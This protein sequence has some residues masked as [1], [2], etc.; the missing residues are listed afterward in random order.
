[1]HGAIWIGI[2]F[3]V[4][5][6]ALFSGLNLALFSVS[7]LRLE[8]EAKAGSVAARKILDLRQNS[9]FLLT[10]ILWGNVGINVLLT[11]L[12]GSVLAGVAAFLFSTVLITFVGEILPQAYFSRHALKAGSLLSPVLRVY[13]VLLWPVAKPS[14]ILLDR[15]LGPEGLTFFRERDLEEL[16]KVHVISPETDIGHVEG[17]GALNFL[18]FDDIPVSREGAAVEPLSIVPLPFPD[19]RPAFP[20]IRP[21]LDD[22][23]LQKIQSS[24]RKW[25]V[26]VDEKGEPRMALDADGF[27]R[28]AL[29]GDEPFEP[30]SHCHAPVIV[31]DPAAPLGETLKKLRIHPDRVGDDVID[32]DIILLWAE[33]RRII[34]GSD[35]LG[36]LVRGIVPRE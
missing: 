31:R 35:I 22:P 14:A 18:A 29:Y 33:E 13:Q 11:L 34:T 5:Q 30:H 12:S 28:D 10:T 1:M 26:L 25:V 32:Q 15:W 20:E 8:V 23:F 2:A 9:N 27:I 6:S 24:G 36:R 17:R 19:G 3:C 21:D 4:S 7:R 16:I